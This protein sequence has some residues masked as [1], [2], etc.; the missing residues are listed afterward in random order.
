[1]SNIKDVARL[2]GLSIS[3]ISKYINGGNVLEEN[4]TR[5]DHAIAALDFKVNL[6]ARS[7]KTSKT[8]TVGALLPSLSVSF[9]SDLFSMIEGLLRREGY[10]LIVCSYN[11]DPEQELDKVKFLVGK[12][13]DGIIFVPGRVDVKKVNAIKEIQSHKVPL[14]LL[15]R[16]VAGLEYDRILVDNSGISYAAVEHLLTNRHRR[17]GIM[18]GPND[19]STGYERT[20]GYERVLADYSIPLDPSL[21]RMGD[22]SYESG[23]RLFCEF[24]DMDDPPTAIFATNYDMTLG[25]VTAA[26]ERKLKIPEDISFIG[27]D[28]VRLTKMFNPP[29]SIV[30]QPMELIAEQTASTLVRRMR[31]DYASFPLMLR[32]KGELLLNDSVAAL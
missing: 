10:S 26:Y 31:D 6:T 29:L 2:T 5:I 20:L 22:F 12:Q 25:A 8:M 23:Y 13:V 16:C 19:I 7:L 4:K 9:F 32:L 18:M 17:I 1:M 15:D 28:E 27:F 14:V 30:I 11:N 3:T 24:M 21:M